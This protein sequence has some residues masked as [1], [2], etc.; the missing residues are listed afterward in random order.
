MTIKKTLI[1]C[2][3]IIFCLTS[4][5]AKAQEQDPDVASGNLLTVSDIKIDKTDKNAVA[6]REK[7]LVEAKRKALLELVKRMLDPAD[8]AK[9]KLPDD[10]TIS[11]L[12]MDFEVK[13]EKLSTNR[14][15]ADFTVSFNENTVE[16]IKGAEN[17]F[18]TTTTNQSTET[19]NYAYSPTAETTAASESYSTPVQDKRILVLPYYKTV[20]GKNILWEDPNPWRSSWQEISGKKLATNVSVT[21]PLGDIEDVSL[22]S[23]SDIWQGEPKTIKKLKDK[24]SATEVMI[25]LASRTETGLKVDVYNYRKDNF[26][27]DKSLTEYFDG[28]DYRPVVSDVLANEELFV[29]SGNTLLQ[30]SKDTLKG[31]AMNISMKLANFKD[32]MEAQKRIAS[33]MPKVNF[34]IVSLNNAEVI[35]QIN[36]KSPEAVREIQD[37][38]YAHGLEIKPS[39]NDDGT[40]TLNLKAQE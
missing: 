37:K 15:M 6:A 14:Y 3:F 36:I 12:V 17:A 25:V 22:G 24:Y 20:Y 31:L 2:F 10:Q 35:L 19:S 13:N 30:S 23:S 29:K 32:W 38:F 18:D 40:Y 16:F 21:S 11:T 28:L 4:F 39:D 26:N 7:A 1:F 8:A 33:I 5:G 9:Y 27:L 34:N